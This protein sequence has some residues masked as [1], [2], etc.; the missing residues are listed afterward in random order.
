MLA[1][2][3]ERTRKVRDYKISLANKEKYDTIY[4]VSNLLRMRFREAGFQENVYFFPRS[5]CRETI[6]RKKVEKTTN[7][8]N[9]CYSDERRAW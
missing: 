6:V 4:L 1:A 5:T 8:L 9:S 2:R 7:S 3:L